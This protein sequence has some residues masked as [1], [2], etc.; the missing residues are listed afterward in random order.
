[1]QKYN[2]LWRAPR[3]VDAVRRIPIIL[4]GMRHDLGPG[5]V[6]NVPDN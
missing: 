1:M 6:K 4:T 3:G 2:E 5:G